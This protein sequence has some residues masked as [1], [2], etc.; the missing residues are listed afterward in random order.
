MDFKT[1]KV[2]DYDVQALEVLLMQDPE[3]HN[4]FSQLRKKK[5]RQQKFVYL[6]RFNERNPLY[7][8]KN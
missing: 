8:P 1:G 3:L 5:K 4:E 7:L 6:R 2:Y